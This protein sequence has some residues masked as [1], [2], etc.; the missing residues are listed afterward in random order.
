MFRC[1]RRG[2]WQHGG[3]ERPGFVLYCGLVVQI[4]RGGEDLSRLAFVLHRVTALPAESVLLF[5]LRSTF[6]ACPNASVLFLRGD[7]GQRLR[8]G[9]Y[10]LRDRR[11][12]LRLRWRL[13]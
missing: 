2:P 12:R 4:E 11:W 8:L 3:S 5:D 13:R 10:T 1:R 9:F 6:D 7:H